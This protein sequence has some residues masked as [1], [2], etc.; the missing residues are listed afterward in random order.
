MSSAI[1]HGGG[2]GHVQEG[3]AGSFENEERVSPSGGGESDGEGWAQASKYAHIAEDTQTVNQR[4]Q[5]SSIRV[6]KARTMTRPKMSRLPC[7]SRSRRRIPNLTGLVEFTDDIYA[8]YLGLC[9]SG[10]GGYENVIVALNRN[11]HFDHENDKGDEGDGILEDDIDLATIAGPFPYEDS[12]F[13][14]ESKREFPSDVEYEEHEEELA[15]VPEQAG[16]ES[17]HMNDQLIQEMLDGP[18]NLDPLEPSAYEV[19]GDP[20]DV[21][22]EAEQDLIEN[23][24]KKL[25]GNID[26]DIIEENEDEETGFNEEIEHHIVDFS[27]V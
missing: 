27:Q 20:L 14:T 11:Y 9:S 17:H 16:P 19:E 26:K 12:G 18:I 24:S 3:S 2:R 5:A 22:N 21:A 1:S 10:L 4:V 7:S 25:E 8:K 23:L 6:Y 13:G 15:Y